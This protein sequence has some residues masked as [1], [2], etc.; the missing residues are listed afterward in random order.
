[1]DSESTK[2][3]LVSFRAAT[4][5][6][7]DCLIADSGIDCNVLGM[8]N[9]SPSIDAVVTVVELPH[10]ASSAIDHAAKISAAY[11]E[12]IISVQIYKEVLREL[13]QLVL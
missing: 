9:D 8:L 4:M 13:R 6:F 11:L 1:M 12:C 2:L 10:H 5:L 3:Q 7:C